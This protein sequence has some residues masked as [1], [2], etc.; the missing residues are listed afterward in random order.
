[1]KQKLI[2]IREE[3]Y[4]DRPSFSI[5]GICFLCTDSIINNLCK[6]AK[7]IESVEDTVLIRVQPELREHFNVITSTFSPV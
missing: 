4:K 2:A 6:E 5:I 3:V 7:Y 1:M